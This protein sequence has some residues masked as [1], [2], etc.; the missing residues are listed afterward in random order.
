MLTHPVS[1]CMM[2]KDTSQTKGPY[3]T[4]NADIRDELSL[5]LL[6]SFSHVRPRIK[7]LRPV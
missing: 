3:G 5:S 7:V 4:Q 1:Q 6:I 2:S